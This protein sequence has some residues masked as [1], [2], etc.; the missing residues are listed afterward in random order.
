[1]RYHQIVRSSPRQHMI[2]SI[3]RVA[4]VT[5]PRSPSN[6]TAQ[7]AAAPH[8][9]DCIGLDRNTLSLPGAFEHAYQEREA[10]CRENCGGVYHIEPLGPCSERLYG[11]RFRFAKEADATLFKMFFC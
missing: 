3:N 1:M 11:R 4:A 7:R 2:A 10:W 5:R 8:I 9:V 6:M